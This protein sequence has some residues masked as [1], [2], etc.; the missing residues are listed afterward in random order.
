M[1]CS[2]VIYV[3]L[4]FKASCN[5]HL[6]LTG[7]GPS[8]LTGTTHIYPL[9][10]QTP[11]A[12]Y[13]NRSIY[14]YRNRSIHPY[15][16]NRIYPLHNNRIYPYMNRSIYHIQEQVHLP[17]QEQPTSIPYMNRSIYP[18]REQ[19]H[20]PPTGTNPIY[21]LQEQVYLA[22]QEQAKH[23]TY[24]LLVTEIGCYMTYLFC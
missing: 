2:H 15:R 21:P 7:A 8:T 4:W 16:N 1:L 9:Q 24:D 19:V 11:S 14:P 18:I 5:P 17:L 20:L 13:R 12:P 3:N 23:M 22:S 10:K 6:P